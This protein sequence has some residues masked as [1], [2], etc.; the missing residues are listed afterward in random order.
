[1]CQ[2]KRDAIQ[3]PLVKMLVGIDVYLTLYTSSFINYLAG[4]IY[5]LIYINNI[6][7]IQ[8]TML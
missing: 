2:N 6:I 5:N 1:M 8:S 3:H 7:C 4:V